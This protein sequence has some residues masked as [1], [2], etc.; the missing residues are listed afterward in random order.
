MFRSRKVPQK[1]KPPGSHGGIPQGNL[2]DVFESRASARV[3]R[4]GKSPPLVRRRTRHGKPRV[5][6]GQIGG[7][8]RPG[9]LSGLVRHDGFAVA[10][11]ADSLP[12]ATAL[13]GAKE[14]PSGRPLESRR[15]PWPRGMIA[16]AHAG[17]SVGGCT[18]SGLQARPPFF[19]KLRSI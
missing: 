12:F 5:V 15:E 11:A 1:L 10:A 19:N 3:K 9:S 4:W 13:A 16:A 8:S 14:Q 6:Q 17:N 18:K 2:R 7:E